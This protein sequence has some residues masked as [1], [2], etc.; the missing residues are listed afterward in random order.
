MKKNRI[1]LILNGYKLSLY[2]DYSNVCLVYDTTD[3]YQK[4][5]FQVYIKHIAK[6]NMQVIIDSYTLYYLHFI[7]WF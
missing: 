2:N 5:T 4:E 7:R 6:Y 3:R 1:R